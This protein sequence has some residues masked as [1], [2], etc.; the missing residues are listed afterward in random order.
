MGSEA[1]TTRLKDGQVIS[2][3]KKKKKKRR[4]LDGYD[5]FL[6]DQSDKPK[7]APTVGRLRMLV[8]GEVG[9]GKT[10]FFASFPH[11][12]IF[13]FENKT[14]SVKHWGTGSKPF[15]FLDNQRYADLIDKLIAD[16][17]KGKAPFDTIVMDTGSSFHKFVFQ[18]MTAL[19]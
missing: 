14:G 9:H 8:H 17:H 10:H 7:V 11:T 15:Y 18:Q 19:Y 13:D 2:T 3:K 5:E 4:S 12:A 16:G 1:K 6:D